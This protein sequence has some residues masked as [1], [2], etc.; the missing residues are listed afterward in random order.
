MPVCCERAMSSVTLVGPHRLR[1]GS[2]TDGLEELLDGA[3]PSV[4][5]S[6]PPWGD[7][8]MKTFQTMARKTGQSPEAVTFVQLLEAVARVAGSTTGP[9]F[10]EMGRKWSP[11]AVGILQE[12]GGLHHVHQFAVTYMGGMPMDLHVFTSTWQPIFPVEYAESIQV[13][14]PTMVQRVVAPFAIPGGILLDPCCGFGNSAKAALKFGMRF[15]GNELGATRLARTEK[16]L[17]KAVG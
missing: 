3:R 7:G 9:I 13:E 12:V 5:Y 1:C 15:Y 8:L 16:M 10:I 6:D 14:G 17:R 4:F 2:V 11:Q